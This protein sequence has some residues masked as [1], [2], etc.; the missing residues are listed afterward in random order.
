MDAEKIALPQ[1]VID[2]LKARQIA[3]FEE[4]ITSPGA[5]EEWR[6]S[7]A[8]GFRELLEVRAG[9]LMDPAAFGEAV[10]AALAS[11]TVRS[12]LRPLAKAALQAARSAMLESRDKIGDHLD[13]K[14]RST[15]DALLERPKL[16]PDRL[17]RE[18]SKEEAVEEVMRDVM[19]ETLKEFSEKVN[20]FFAD[21]GLP[22]LLKKLSPFGLGGMK[23][24]LEAF[25]GEFERRMEPETR[26]FL[27]GFAGQGLRRMVE[28]MIAKSDEPKSI[29]VRK[30]IATWLLDQ[31]VR[32]LAS[33]L[34][35]KGAGLFEELA[36]AV[37]E[38]AAASEEL[39]K[40]RRSQIEA[41]FEAHKDKTVREAL[42]AFGATAPPDV[43]ALARAAWPFARAVLSTP[44]ARAWF[45]QVID[46]FYREATVPV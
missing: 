26:R 23:K 12:T 33:S 38:Q 9:D 27:H 13:A 37:A 43:D 6:Q 4:R 1:A 36:L 2:S 34:D 30:R 17:A 25:R 15:L 8:S 39:R 40:R 20:P 3:F 21:W 32:T 14:A 19:Y 28:Q 35:E 18:I 22:A 5:E 46:E 10:D 42:A 45:A 24:G 16:F 7:V 29:A 11:E 41:A 31:E 44:S